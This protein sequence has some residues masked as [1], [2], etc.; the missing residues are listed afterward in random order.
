[1]D[2]AGPAHR[3]AFDEMRALGVQLIEVKLPQLPY[4]A[5]MLLMSAESAAYFEE[6]TLANVDE[7]IDF[8]DLNPGSP[9]V[10]RRARLYSA[11]DYVQADRLRR[12][13]MEQWH[14][15]FTQV[16]MIAGP[17]YGRGGAVGALSLTGHPGLTFRIGFEQ[18]PTRR[19]GVDQTRKHRV[20]VNL[21]LHGRLFEEGRMFTLARAL[22]EKLAVWSERPP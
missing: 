8:G 18:A 15:L 4:E 13:A 10:Y 7:Q 19:P 11:V 16:D 14:D 12:L 22:E 20:T 21:T 3:R 1:M 6:L 5:I 2:A 9:A 17:T